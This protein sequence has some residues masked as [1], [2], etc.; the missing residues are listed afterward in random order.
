MIMTAVLL[1]GG[2]RARF[3]P[4][5]P[6]PARDHDRSQRP[7]PFRVVA[8]QNATRD[9]S[10]VDPLAP[11]RTVRGR[12][13]PQMEARAQV[14]AER[15]IT[16]VLNSLDLNAIIAR[17][18]L[19][20]VLARVDIEEPIDRIQINEVLSRV[21][22]NSL[23]ARVDLN[24]VVERVDVEEPIDRIQIN[25]VLDRIDLNAVI[26]RVD[27]NQVIAKVDLDAVMERVD[28]NAVAQ[29]IDVE[30]LVS[31]TDLGAVIAR[32]SSGIASDLF[33]VI[34]SRTVGIDESIARLVAR[35][36]R[37]PYT[38]PPGPPAGLTAAAGS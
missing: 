14:I 6:V 21:D 19:N 17:I 27:L 38:G 5:F 20:A 35:L 29:R 12:L 28:I 30:T 13:A 15:V 36:R 33:D 31:Q 3:P 23:L 26:D 25:E 4:R 10:R 34:R 9:N 8:R 2:T 32:S 22:L 24:A 7:H 18:D 16:L 1:P 37:R 11:L